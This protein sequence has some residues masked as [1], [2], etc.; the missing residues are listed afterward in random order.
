MNLLMNLLRF[1]MA[2]VLLAVS[3]TFAQDVMMDKPDLEGLVIT[4]GTDATYPPFESINAEGEVVG[5][6]VDVTTA[7]C[8]II[9]CVL[10]YQPTAWDG[11]FP[12]LAMGEF[13]MVMSSVTI[14]AER[15][16]IVDFSK[17]YFTVS[18]AVMLRPEDAEFTV[19]EIQADE[20]MI[21]GAQI[22]TT[23][24]YLAEELVGRERVRVYDSFATT[25]PAL[26]NGDIDAIIID[27]AQAE[28]YEQEYAG[29]V[30]VAIRGVVGSSAEHLGFAFQEG[31]ELID[32]FNAGLEI[33]REEGTLEEL[34]E[35]Y[36]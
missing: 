11:I 6:D 12:A 16:Q 36:F 4:V 23:N 5:F 31:S 10:E 9:N 22:G 13:D 2:F 20:G 28:A 1:S 32:Y 24:A 7:I 18:Q 29:E 30:T 14:T 26:L 17:P 35:R 25:V 21:L 3:F 15:D 19:E 27:D 33:L 34:Y 8:E